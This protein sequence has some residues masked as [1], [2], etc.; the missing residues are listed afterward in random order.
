MTPNR[1]ASQMEASVSAEE[2]ED[3]DEA[4]LCCPTLDGPSPALGGLYHPSPDQ[5][6]STQASGQHSQPRPPP[7]AIR[8]L[9]PDDFIGEWIWERIKDL[10]F[11][12]SPLPNSCVEDFYSIF[13]IYIASTTPN[14]GCPNQIPIITIVSFEW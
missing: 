12:R 3:H 10:R 14:S 8:E 5:E 9:R 6:A 4:L 1:F 13:S 7:T 2:A 11:S